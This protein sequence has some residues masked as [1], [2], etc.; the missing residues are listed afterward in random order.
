[1]SA[2]CAAIDAALRHVS[3]AKGPSSNYT[4]V[5]TTNT[6]IDKHKCTDTRT[7]VNRQTHK[8]ILIQTHKC[9][10][11]CADTH[12]HNLGDRNTASETDTQTQT[13][14]WTDR[15]MHSHTRRGAQIRGTYRCTHSHTDTQTHCCSMC[16]STTDKISKWPHKSTL[17]LFVGVLRPTNIESH[18][19]TSTY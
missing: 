12:T 2:S 4:A 13:D 10:Q 14:K 6:H 7:R 17:G 1:M 8:Y 5:W 11:R 19:R 15:Y 3:F 16:A 18:I 9:R